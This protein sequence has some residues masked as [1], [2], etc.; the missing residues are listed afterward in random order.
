MEITLREQILV[1]CRHLLSHLNRDPA[2][3]SFGCFDRRYWA[4][5][6]TDFPESTF[7]RN[8]A[9]L[10]WYMNQPEAKNKSAI[11]RWIKQ[12]LLF[13]TRIQHRD[14]SF[15]QAYPFEH[16]YGAT[17]FLLPDLI[18]AY[19]AISDTLKEKER[20]YILKSLWKAADRLTTGSEKHDFIAN[21]LA[22]AAF[23]LYKASNLLNNKKYLYK[24]NLIVDKILAKQ[25]N[26]GWFPEYGGAD[27]GYQTL[28]M[29]YLAQIFR[30]VP[31]DELR[32]AL[33]T[34][35]QFL[36]YFA[37]PDGTFGGEYGS[38]RTEIYY[39]G[40][41]ALL[42]DQFP[43]AAALND[44]MKAS[45]TEG[46]TTTV[47]DVDVGNLAPLLSNYILALEAPDSLTTFD[48][49]PMDKN[50]IHQYFDLAGIAIHGNNHYY[51]IIGVSN[52]GVTKIYQRNPKRIILDDCGLLGTTQ[53]GN[54]VTSQV[55]DPQAKIVVD[56]KTIQI[57]TRLGFISS[58]SPNPANYL[59]LRL[60]N[61]T[62]MRIP[63]LNEWIKKLLVNILIKKE[64]FLPIQRTR[65]IEFG[66]AKITV[67]D[68]INKDV[69]T[70][71]IQLQMALKFSA[72]HMASSRYFSPSQCDIGD[73]INLDCDVL[74]HTGNITQ[75]LQIDAKHSTVV[76]LL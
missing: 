19:D 4:W 33:K 21:H 9:P 12:A 37:H 66:Q 45:I 63:F 49:L 72:I 26:E 22:G 23:G 13:T 44:P 43:L 2:S 40:G 34:S 61:L 70:D 56:D 5:K 48:P 65:R 25:S 57:S 32:D 3:A 71:I 46:T 10:A 62:F 69:S 42:A 6:L 76:R 47:M 38:R 30:A 1:S 29:Y 54:L 14:G 52:G 75:S 67:V 17:A 7:Q 74:N 73:A 39:P 35:L 24:C 55:S 41:I 15:D 16:S 50:D 51:T 8:V 68:R 58:T 28:C 59:L 36:Q 64:D 60:A 11:G 53:R 31:S 20:A 18:T 27:P